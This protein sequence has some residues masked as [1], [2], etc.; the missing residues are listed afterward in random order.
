MDRRQRWG[1][2]DWEDAR[3][4]NDGGVTGG[5]GPQLAVEYIVCVERK[6]GNWFYMSAR[7]L[8]N[9]SAA[10]KRN[11]V[12]I[13]RQHCGDAAAAVPS[14]VMSVWSKCQCHNV[15]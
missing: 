6:N 3:L 13:I 5:C 7:A 2:R 9:A 11:I 10:V 12:R 1:R 4:G 8:S 14:A 15:T